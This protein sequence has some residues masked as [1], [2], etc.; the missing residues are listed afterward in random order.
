MKNYSDLK[1][2]FPRMAIDLK[3][4]PDDHLSVLLEKAEKHVIQLAIE[5]CKGNQSTAALALGIS[6]GTLRTKLR[7]YFGAKYFHR[8]L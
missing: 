2:D 5:R 1:L 7:K 6:R 4:S 8:E 3:L